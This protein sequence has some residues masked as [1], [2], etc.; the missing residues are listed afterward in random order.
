MLKRTEIR[1]RYGIK[2]DGTADC[3]ATYW[4]PCCAVI[5]HDKE[6]I[7]RTSAGPVAQGYQPNKEGMVMPQQQPQHHHQQQHAA[8]LP[9]HK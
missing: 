1:E 9:Q 2:G 8:P 4:C 3:C 5:Q 6:V 7:A